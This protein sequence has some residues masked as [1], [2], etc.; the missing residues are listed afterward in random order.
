M[1]SLITTAK[2]FRL[3]HSMISPRRKLVMRPSAGVNRRP[4]S[5]GMPMAAKYSGEAVR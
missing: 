2:R 5:S 3:A 1:D 4:R